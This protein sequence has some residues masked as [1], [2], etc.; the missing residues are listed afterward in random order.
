MQASQSKLILFVA[1]HT[2]QRIHH[3]PRSLKPSRVFTLFS[4]IC[5]QISKTR[6]PKDQFAFV[7]DET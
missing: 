5:F 6:A 2:T 1:Q 4:S 3:P 7:A